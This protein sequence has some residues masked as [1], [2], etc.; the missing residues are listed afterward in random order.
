MFVY[1]YL[2]ILEL[3]PRHN[4]LEIASKGNELQLM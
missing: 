4:E 2:L 3:E 1:E